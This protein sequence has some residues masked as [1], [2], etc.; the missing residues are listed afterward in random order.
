MSSLM[1]SQLNSGF[2]I[3]Y[4][5]AAPEGAVRA[6]VVFIHGSG[7]GASG[8]SN[9]H[10]NIEAFVSAGY[11]VLVPDLPGYG[12]S[13]KPTDVQ[14]TLDYFVSIMHEWLDHLSLSDYHLVGNSLGGAIAIGMS[15]ARPAATKSLILMASGGIESRETYFNMPGIQAMVKYPMGSPEF[16]RD[17]LAQLLT[18]L[19]FDPT[20]ITDELV[21]QR[22]ATLQTQNATVLATMAIPDLTEQLADLNCPVLSFWGREDRFCPVSGANKLFNNCKQIQCVNVS[23]CG[24]WV[25]VEYP[26]LF[27]RESLAF[28]EH[29]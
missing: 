10:Q 15:L 8:K 17:V 24:H 26:E 19:V 12:L 29:N 20:H 9:F 22:W 18:Q 14:Y 21:D 16:T 6:C 7:P 4:I 25:M 11:R 13:D 27:N 1:Q 3:S 23:Q 2:N 5:D 28:L